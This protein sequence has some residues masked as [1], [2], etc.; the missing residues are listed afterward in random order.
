[1]VVICLGP[2]C[3]PIWPLIALAMKP[4]WDRFVPAGIKTKLAHL[5][6]FATQRL[7][8]PRKAQSPQNRLATQDKQHILKIETEEEFNQILQTSPTVLAKFTAT[9]CGP[10]QAISPVVYTLAAEYPKLKF[11]EIDIDTLDN[12]AFSRGVSSIP[13]FHIYKDRVKVGEVV[14]V[15]QHQLRSLIHDASTSSRDIVKAGKRK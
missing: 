5:W 12:L 9:W 7:C 1:M 15:N 2:V 11:I 13:A 4:L 14:G 10:C 8:P 6:G 3:V